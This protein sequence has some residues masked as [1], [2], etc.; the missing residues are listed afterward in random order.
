MVLDYRHE[1]LV[2]GQET[3]LEFGKYCFFSRV[4]RISLACWVCQ[5]LA[6]AYR[7]AANPVVKGGWGLACVFNL[8]PGEALQPGRGCAPGLPSGG[9]RYPGQT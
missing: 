4:V 1:S 9:R 3:H 2:P 5:P 6:E 8:P 7:Q